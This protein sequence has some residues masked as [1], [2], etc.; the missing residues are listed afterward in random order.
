MTTAVVKVIGTGGDYTSFST[1]LA[2]WEAAKPVD[3]TAFRT[4]TTQAGS[5][6]STIVLDSGAT[7]S[8][9]VGHAVWCNARPS[10][11]R[12]IVSGS[13]ATA[14]IAELR[15]SS[16]VASN[17]TWDNT[18]GTEDFTI[19]SCIWEGRVFGALTDAFSLGGSTT[20]LSKYTKLTPV[21]GGSF[22]D[23]VNAATNPLRFDNGVGA[24]IVNNSYGSGI[25][26]NAN[27]AFRLEN[28][29]IANVY[30]YGVCA[31][32][33][34]TLQP[35]SMSRCIL[36]QFGPGPAFQIYGSGAVATNSVAIHRNAGTINN[37]ALVMNSSRAVNCLFVRPSDLTP[38][39][40]GVTGVYAAASLKNCGVFGASAVYSG[41][42][43]NSTT[44]LTDLASPAGGWTGGVAFDNTTFENTLDGTH[45]F[46]PVSGSALID[47]GTT[48][49]IYGT[50]DIIGTVR[51]VGSAYDVGPWEFVSGGGGGSITG[52]G[53]LAAGAA[54]A[55]GA[56]VSLSTGT[57]ALL[58]G[59][60]SLS[61]VGGDITGTGVLAASSA[62]V[63]GS[64]TISGEETGHVVVGAVSYAKKIIP[65]A[66]ITGF[67]RLVSAPSKMNGKAVANWDDQNTL[68]LLLIAA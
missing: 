53:A 54:S 29:Q 16:E 48:D 34:N 31:T 42:D 25:D 47:A 67:G 58:S 39:I 1:G 26:N 17:S 66:E 55:D 46:R 35:G 4:N 6:S 45:D 10:E 13:G 49:V 52:S 64:G 65:L 40:A 37:I 7:A 51:P 30:Y 62:S 23:D 27:E 57:G 38:A 19:D 50:P 2:D 59:P 41:T 12:L 8:D 9:Y 14:T 18:P 21:I 11:K 20:S 3:L 61:G 43:P 24:S 32:F 28:L 33:I 5:T 56:G 63:S 68:A 36:E 15:D 22:I 44:N 60:S